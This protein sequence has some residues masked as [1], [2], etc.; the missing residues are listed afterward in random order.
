MTSGWT[1][2]S[3]LAAIAASAGALTLG[4]TARRAAAIGRSSKFRFAQ[5]QLGAGWNPRPDAIRRLGWELAKRTSIDVDLETAI[6]TPNSERL[7][8]TPLLYLAADR[9]FAVPPPAQVEALRRLLTYGGFLLIDSAEGAAGGDVDA[10]VRKLVAA[11]FPSPSRGLEPV[12]VDHVV[13]KS[14]YLL[15]SAAGRVAASPIMEAVTVGERLAVAYVQ[16]DLGGAWMRD[17]YGNYQF[18]CEPD[19]EPQREAAFRLGVNVVM[20]ALCLDY[21]TDQVHVPF[22][23]RRRRW[24]PDDG[25]AMPAAPPVA[26]GPPG[27]GTRP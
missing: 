17:S 13:Y 1:R 26:P 2:R 19:G 23:M 20:Y 9:T 7:H 11:I 10:A 12:P 14:F 24:K 15:E 4:G 6:V 25:A 16:N 18:A 5:L 3:V 22:I 21:K 8:E 27:S